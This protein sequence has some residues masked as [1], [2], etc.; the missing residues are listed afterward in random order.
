MATAPIPD[1]DPGLY[2][3]RPLLNAGQLATWWRSVKDPSEPD[4][5]ANPHVTVAYSKVTFPWTNDLKPVVIQPTDIKGFGVLG[6]DRAVVLFLDSSRL[7]QR[8]QETVNAGAQWS[9]P[10]YHPHMTLFFLDSNYDQSAS[11]PRAWHNDDPAHYPPLPDFPLIFGPEL[12]STLGDDCY[13]RAYAAWR[14]VRMPLA[15]GGTRFNQ[16][17]DPKDGEFASGDG[18]GDGKSEKAMLAINTYKPSTAAKQR[19]GEAE[20]ARLAKL[21]GMINTDDN[22]PFDLLAGGNAVE[23]KTVMDNNNDKITVHPSSRLRK[24]AFAKLHG[25]V[26]HTV[27]IDVRDGKRAYY[28]RKGVGA[29]RLGS[30]ERLSVAELRGRLTA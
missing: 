13:A 25:L 21:V 17:H 29:F 15:F 22:A 30:M 16:N 7:E 18:G 6:K 12:S 9:Y 20:Q 5:D 2:V 28:Y 23:V 3:G 27:A 26:S 10:D 19:K 11:V 4:L 14:A 1:S 8:W 24:E